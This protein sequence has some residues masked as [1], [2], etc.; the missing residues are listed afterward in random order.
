LANLPDVVR[1]QELEELAFGRRRACAAVG[2]LCLAVLM[3]VAPVLL[4]AGVVSWEP[5]S[6]ATAVA[7]GLAAVVGAVKS[8]AVVGGLAARFVAG[9]RPQSAAVAVD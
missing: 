2:V 8:T 1:S 5:G 9:F 4:A 3:I 7:A 6:L